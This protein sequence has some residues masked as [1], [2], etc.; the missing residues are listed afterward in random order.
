MAAPL[1][2]WHIHADFAIAPP[3]GPDRVVLIFVAATP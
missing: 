3:G 1:W 2:N